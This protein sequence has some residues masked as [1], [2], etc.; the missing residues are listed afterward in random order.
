MWNLKKKKNHINELFTK[1]K[2]SHRC[3]IQ[4]MVTRENGGGDKLGDL[5]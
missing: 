5:N 4:T 3:R 1:Q 2:Q